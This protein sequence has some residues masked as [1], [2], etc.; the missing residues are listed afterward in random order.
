MISGSVGRLPYIKIPTL[1]IFPANQMKNIMVP[2]KMIIDNKISVNGGVWTEIRVNI[3]IGEKNGIIDE[4]LLRLLVG[5]LI[6]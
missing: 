2:I 1:K 4:I 6:I 5:L 3:V